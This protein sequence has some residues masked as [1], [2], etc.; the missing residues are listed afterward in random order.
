MKQ[1]EIQSRNREIALMLGFKY[2]KTKKSYNIEKVNDTNSIFH[3]ASIDNDTYEYNIRL[4]KNIHYIYEIDLAF[5]LD[6]NWLMEAKRFAE[7]KGLDISIRGH[8]VM[9]YS[10]FR[11]FYHIR[12]VEPKLDADVDDSS[13]IEAV[14]IAV[15]D[16]A[17]L[18]NNK[19]L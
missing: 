18:Y 10:P 9:V 15:S 16:F 11:K 3:N 6:W 2:V 14:F 8:E 1:Q 12:L 4:L 17:K 7:R 19:E 13:I 5:H